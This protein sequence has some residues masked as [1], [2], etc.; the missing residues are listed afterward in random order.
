MTVR[1]LLADDEALVRAG[2]RMILEAEP[3][4]E[5]VGEAA[6]GVDALTMCR[7]L[8]PDVALVDIRMPKLDGIQAARRI[9]ADAGNRTAVVMLTTFDAD[10]HVVEALRAGA[11][12]FL[13]KSMPREQLVAAVRTAVSGD[14]LLAPTLL[15]RLLDDFVGRADARPRPAP[16]IDQLT[17]REEEVLRLVA[18]GLSNAEIAAG[19][20]LGEGTVKTHVARVLAKLGVRDRVQAVVVAYESGLVRPGRP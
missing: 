8:R 10:E 19:L 2:L 3:G 16:G 12:G 1:I 6:D 11:T 20:V 4:L 7:E 17:P 18:R 9:T 13:L 5:V 15:R 14:S